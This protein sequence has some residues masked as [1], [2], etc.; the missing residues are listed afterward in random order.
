MVTILELAQL[1]GHI[2][3]PNDGSYGGLRI[4]HNTQQ[5]IRKIPKPSGWYRLEDV[6][7]HMT[8]GNP[9]Y[10]QLYVK[11]DKGYAKD[12]VVAI[13]GTKFEIF[14]N[15]WQDIKWWSDVVGNGSHDK[16][17]A[18]LGK[19]IHFHRK[20]R[21]YVYRYFPHISKIVLTGHSLGGAIA[22]LLTLT[23]AYAPV[24]A[25]NAPGCGH[26]PGV[27]MDRFNLLH[28]VDSH[29]G[30][31][32]KVG[33]SLGHI[34]VIDIPDDEEEAKV[35]FDAYNE[36]ENQALNI[37]DKAVDKYAQGSVL[38]S[39]FKAALGELKLFN[40]VTAMGGIDNFKNLQERYSRCE[41]RFKPHWYDLQVWMQTST[42]ASACESEAKISE[43]KKVIME[44]H[45]IKNVVKTLCREQYARIRT[46]V[47]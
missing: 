12:A 47:L 38:A 33:V 25:F 30:I 45:A 35:L 31:F 1:A 11:F 41:A 19:A 39:G 44:Q 36:S 17:P 23:H 6:D 14:N 2:Y 15:L 5:E 4:E 13:R 42:K 37:A 9:F 20:C 3:T 8:S 28:N 16:L 43:F 7:P 29:Y 22:K 40:L 10:A 26:M 18:Y 21:D 32:N 27:H 24:A 34:H 46:Q